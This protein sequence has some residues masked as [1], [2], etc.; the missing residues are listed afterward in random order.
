VFANP[1][2]AEIRARDA[3][4]FVVIARRTALDDRRL[5]AALPA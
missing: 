2:D 3:G 5:M 4:A 1:S